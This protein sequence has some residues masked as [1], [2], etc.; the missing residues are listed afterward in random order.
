M[1]LGESQSC[2]SKGSPS[3]VVFNGVDDG[4]ALQLEVDQ[5]EPGQQ[6]Q[7]GR[8]RNLQKVKVKSFLVGNSNGETD[9]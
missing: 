4:V 9:G 5:L 6:L 2:R 3:V 1:M 7:L 8:V